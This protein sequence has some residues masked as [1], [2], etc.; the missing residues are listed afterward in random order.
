MDDVSPLAGLAVL[1]IEDEPLISMLMEQMLDDLGCRV[2]GPCASLAAA[3][4]ACATP[5]FDLALVDLKLGSISSA[6]V[7]ECLAK[8]G[9]PFAIVTGDSLVD[10][11]N[12]AGAILNKPFDLEGLGRTIGVLAEAIRR[13]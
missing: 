4:E 10:A 9:I 2:V 3:L 7:V 13:Q 1:V 6:P 12:G 8:S 11:S 5:A